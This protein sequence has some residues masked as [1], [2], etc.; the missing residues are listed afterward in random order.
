MSIPI[1]MGILG[2]ARIAPNALIRPARQVEGV[3]AYGV[4]A[5]D[6]DR[7][8]QFAARHSLAR[9][10]E[11][12]E[13]M[14]AD[15]KLVAIY[16]PL[17]NSLHCPWTINALRAGKHVLCEKP[18]ASN[19][20]QAQQMANVASETGL[21]LMEAFHNLYHPLAMRAQELIQSGVIGSLRH[22]EAHFCIPLLR[23][24]DIRYDYN[25]AGGAT[26]DLGCYTIRLLRYL[27]NAE[28]QVTSARAY[29]SS[30]QVDRYME[31][32]FTFPNA[33]GADISGRM[34]CSFFSRKLLYIA[35]TA[36][37]ERGEIRLLNPILP[38]LFNRLSVRA[39][40]RTHT[41]SISG[42]T[43]YVYQLRAFAN[44][45]RDGAHILTDAQDAVAN[46]RVIDAVYEKAGLQLRGLETF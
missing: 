36:R 43:T 39:G 41:E 3:Q 38:H 31:A 23:F 13:A 1:T 12:Y 33:T 17:P 29:L 32:S 45:V 42:E 34:T 2:A 9:T 22:V 7:A 8:Q 37:G 44:A 4:A 20:D 24:N 18:L 35:A 15:P 10:Y 27:T 28:P 30:P 21:V 11:S 46:M 14:L 6:P 19:A 5:R 25:L 16:N 26:M 40:G